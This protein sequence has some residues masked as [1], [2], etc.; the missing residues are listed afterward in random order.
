MYSCKYLIMRAHI[1]ANFDVNL[2]GSLARII[3][4]QNKTRGLKL[5]FSFLFCAA[6]SRE[7]ESAVDE[8]DGI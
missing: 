3:R 6:F 1:A 4:G 8:R 7:R 5:Q 2:R